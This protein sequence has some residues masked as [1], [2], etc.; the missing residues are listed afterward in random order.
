[1]RSSTCCAVLFALLALSGGCRD[2]S[3]PAPEARST[4]VPP[5]ETSTIT[6]SPSAL[7][8]K[9]AKEP[10]PKPALVLPSAT[11]SAVASASASAAVEP[12]APPPDP[13]LDCDVVV[14]PED[15]QEACGISVTAAA[16]QPTADIGVDPTCSRRWSSKES[17]TLSLFIARHPSGDEAKERYKEIEGDV[18]GVAV[19]AGL[20]D[21][22]RRYVKKGA[23][24]DPIY[25]VEAVKG[26]F[27]LRVFGPK[28]TIGQTTVGPVC[29]DAGLEK[30]AKKALE[31]LP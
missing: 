25:N 26:R 2:E 29:D 9:P 14:T 5:R 1:M 20:G 13:S 21:L 12:P 17:G 24:G 23:S 8:P 22:A 3:P 31:R 19:I 16:D 27:D 15:V 18:S 6:P 28:I 7:A 10:T 30:L 4:Q 11:A